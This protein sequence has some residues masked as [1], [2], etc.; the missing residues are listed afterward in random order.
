VS[1]G[2]VS[3][4]AETDCPLTVPL[5]VTAISGKTAFSRSL[6]SEKASEL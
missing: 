4:T 1:F 6:A 3:V 2:L 5:T